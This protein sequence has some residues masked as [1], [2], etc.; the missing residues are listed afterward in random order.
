MKNKMKNGLI[1]EIYRNRQLMG[2]SILTEAPPGG[3]LDDVIKLAKG[4]IGK[5]GVVSKEFDDIVKA[6]EKHQSGTIKLSDDELIKNYAK[7]ANTYKEIGAELA[8]RIIQSLDDVTKKQL[9]AIKNDIQQFKDVG[10]TLEEVTAYV[11]KLFN[12]GSISSPIDQVEILL[13]NDLD[14]FTKNI[15]KTGTSSTRVK[16]ASN[17]LNKNPSEIP[18]VGTDFLN[19]LQKLYRAKGLGSIMQPLNSMRQG[20][21][22]FWAS[23]GELVDETLQL[24]KTFE[25]AETNLSQ[26]NDILKK[27]SSNLEEIGKKDVHIFEDYN[28]WLNTYVKP[29][30]YD[31]WLEISKTE[32]FKKATAIFNG[33]A[34]QEYEKTALSAQAR[35]TAVMQQIKDILYP[36]RWLGDTMLSKVAKGGK[37]KISKWSKWGKILGGQEFSEF[38]RWLFYGGTRTPTQYVEYGLKFGWL[39]LGKDLFLSYLR[40]ILVWNLWISI[41]DLI[42]DIFAAPL[43]DSDWDMFDMVQKNYASYEER[44]IKNIGPI[45]LESE[46]D[47]AGIES[48]F[49]FFARAGVNLPVYYVDNLFRAQSLIPGLG[50]DAF[51][52]LQEMSRKLTPEEIESLRTRAGELR[53]R[54]VEE[55]DRVVNELEEVSDRPIP[56]ELRDT[57][58]LNW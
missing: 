11:Q 41:L 55:R 32:G 27:I 39:G 43:A 50:D 7:M 52:L 37:E 1:S 48:L 47:D 10:A 14:D 28:R 40:R 30:S 34:L 42:T 22:D 23:S 21:K 26:K 45:N 36:S 9:S 51:V 35:R 25:S 20:W 44:A 2:L 24:T 18:L 4:F 38:R 6:L 29:V 17:L 54:A 56:Q 46:K 58:I 33:A 19:K 3:L 16:G 12:N 8:P 13:K 57:T 31:D 49:K 15:F 53:T 5:G